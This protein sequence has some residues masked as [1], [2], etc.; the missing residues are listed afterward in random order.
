MQKISYDV[1]FIPGHLRQNDQY[2]S[3]T[4]LQ[5]LNLLEIFLL[6]VTPGVKV[7]LVS[8][9]HSLNEIQLAYQEPLQ[10]RSHIQ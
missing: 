5:N 7:T 2:A 1:D 8:S 6:K 4:F 10:T 9:C 3:Y